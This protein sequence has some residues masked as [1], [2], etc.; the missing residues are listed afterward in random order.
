MGTQ[1]DSPR[2]R[3]INALK[4]SVVPEVWASN[5][6]FVTSLRSQIKQHT[7]VTNPII[8]VL[9]EG[10]FHFS[11]IKKIHLEYRHAIVQV[12][13]DALLMAQFQTRQ[14]EPRLSPSSK[15]PA[16]FLLTLNVLDE[17][18]FQPGHDSADYYQ[19]NPAY[20]HYPL[21]EN[22]LN[23]LGVT[24]QE[25]Q[26]YAPSLR[27]AAV[28]N[29]L[30]ASYS[31][32]IEVVALLA[33]AEQQVIIYSP[34]LREAT[35]A[36]GINVDHGYYH[37]HGVTSDGD[38]DAADDDHENDLWLALTQAC[39]PEDYDLLRAIC[40]EYCDLWNEFWNHQR[41]A[42][43]GDAQSELSALIE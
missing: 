32:Y 43:C 29:F 24:I 39:V 34:P 26:A 6:D 37:V 33:V 14:L 18:G 25:R 11:T 1:F 40:F 9:N 19:G 10:T 41:S 35:K 4:E 22:V 21:F 30:E 7:F 16:R 8:D 36:V 2:E 3:A 28:R 17:F 42:S 20:A 15:I 31:S 13:T 23:D 27:S 38:T 12:F 5:H